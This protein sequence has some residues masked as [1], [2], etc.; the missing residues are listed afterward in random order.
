MLMEYQ[1]KETGHKIKAIHFTANSIDE[2]VNMLFQPLHY[3]EI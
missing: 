3:L 1:N 2:T